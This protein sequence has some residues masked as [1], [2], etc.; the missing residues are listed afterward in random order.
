ML[1]CDVLKIVVDSDMEPQT[2]DAHPQSTCF[3]LEQTKVGFIKNYWGSSLDLGVTIICMLSSRN[4]KICNL[5]NI[6]SLGNKV[7]SIFYEQF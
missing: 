5:L 4:S 6:Y 2:L 3:M 1:R 7:N